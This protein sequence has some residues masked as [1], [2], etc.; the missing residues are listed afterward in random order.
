MDEFVGGAGNDTFNG[1]IDGTTGAVATTLTALD[2]IDGGA[3]TDTFKLNVL[4]GIGD[5]GTAVT[6]LPT[7]IVVQN[8]EN[9][10]V[11]TAVD[12]TADFS[13]WA[14]LTS[15]SVTEAAGLI[16]LTAED[17]TAVTTSGTKG[18]VTVDG[19][20]NVSV[21]VNK[22]TGAVTLDN[23]AGAISIT[24]SDFEGANIATTDGTDVTIDVSAKAAT[25]NITVGTAGNEQSGAVSVTQTLNSDGEAALNNGDTAIAVTGGTTIAVTVNAISDAKK[26]TSD[27]DITVGSISVTG[28]EDTT[29]VTVVQNASVTTVTKA[30]KALVP[31][32]Q[33]LTFKA[34]AN[35]ESTTVN[36]LTFT[37]AKA[38]T[39]GQ[40]AQAFAGLTKDD[41]QSETGPTANGVY[42]GDFDTVSGWKSGSASVPCG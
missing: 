42:S 20:S 28:S 6:A 19:G 36:G 5:A 21:T 35:G 27:F 39:A 10:V 3:G 17:T 15:L 14:G 30:A 18:A 13:T 9:A 41:T 23:A 26:E 37:A 40:V 4:N 38:L 29:D 25:G 22:D 11:R 31:A 2:S 33:E 16:D 8:V 32:T 24:G 34:L 7:G 12:L 1:V